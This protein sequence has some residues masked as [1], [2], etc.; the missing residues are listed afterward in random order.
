M[1]VNIHIHPHLKLLQTT[2][3]TATVLAMSTFSCA[4]TRGE[5]CRGKFMLKLHCLGE[6]SNSLQQSFP[7]SNGFHVCVKAK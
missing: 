5:V 2:L 7:P 6:E 3:V 4:H 1:R